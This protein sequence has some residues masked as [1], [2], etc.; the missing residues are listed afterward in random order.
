MTERLAAGLFHLK[1]PNGHT[2]LAHTPRRL[3]EQVQEAGPGDR[4]TVEMTPFDMSK[5]RVKSKN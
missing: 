4:L 2:I 5:G 3:L 1:L